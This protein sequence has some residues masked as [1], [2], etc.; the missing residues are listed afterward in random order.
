MVANLYGNPHSTSP[1]SELSTVRVTDVRTRLLRFFRADPD[2]F[3]LVFVA[4]ATAAIKLVAEAFREVE[5]PGFW[6]G[7]HR[8]AHTSL[9]GIRQVATSSRCFESDE[10]VD[11]W[12]R[13][14]GTGKPL[15]GTTGANV[16]LL[17]Y[18]A[19]SNMNGHRMPLRWAGAAR[20]TNGQAPNHRIYT[21]LD[22]AAYVM[23]AQLDLSDENTAPD[24]TALSLY[25]I[26]GFPDMG[27]LIVRKAAGDLLR[28][29]RY[30]GGGTVE[31]VTV[32]NDPW[33]AKKEGT[34]HDALEDGT[35]PV[36][37]IVAL[38]HALD[39]HAETFGTMTNVSEHTCALAAHTYLRLQ[40][41]RHANGRQ[42]CIIYKDEGSKYGD[43][44]TQG[45]TIAF[46]IQ[47]SEG[48]WI[49]KS[50]VERLAIARG[51]HL[52][53]GGVCNAGGIAKFCDLAY[54]ELRRNFSEGMRCGDDL[55]II[56]GKPTGVVRIS[57]GAMSSQQDANTLLRFV[58]E[59]FVEK[60]I[61][62]KTSQCSAALIVP[63]KCNVSN[64]TVFPIA[65]CAGWAVPANVNWT[66]SERGLAWDQEWCVVA[67]GTDA[68]LD[69]VKYP[70]MMLIK[71]ELDVE[72][73]TLRLIGPSENDTPSTLNISL[74]DSPLEQE[75]SDAKHIQADSY[76]SQAIGTFFANIIGV[77]STLS[78]FRDHR[79]VA[80][81]RQSAPSL[82]ST[83][84]YFVTVSTSSDNSSANLVLT[85]A[86]AWWDNKYF[87]VNQVL[88]EKVVASSKDAA[89]RVYNFRFLHDLHDRSAAAQDP[90]IK[91]GDAV[92]SSTVESISQE[93]SIPAVV[94]DQPTCAKLERLKKSTSL[95]DFASLMQSHQ[96][97]MKST[98][99]LSRAR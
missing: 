28:R 99:R 30:F 17:A 37:Q 93:L 79:R 1:S 71:P 46:N 56:G 80:K 23:T 74:W 90:C 66:V 68:P 88:F 39:V 18:P 4:N 3:D 15:E 77:P 29:R 33:H 67:K 44:V 95:T 49:G 20:Q 86:P 13:T 21:L 60:N 32:M 27:A 48:S 62:E 73:G 47:N 75:Q 11:A 84:E 64:L 12:L 31:M 25:K 52:R 58:D 83:K 14:A 45:P 50:D 42:V 26:F 40:A 16:G 41:L 5:E 7:Y 81:D 96:S 94:A 61:I 38:G 10:E 72:R 36:H 54:W 76:Q 51:I 59:H 69:S 57:F 43:S 91:V 8:D 35:L 89:S 6:Y 2:H 63:A 9:V 87:K 22:A 65:G 85:N 24:F 97:R 70:R 19:Q 98:L 82:S 92:H 53:T 78:R 55:D 34:L